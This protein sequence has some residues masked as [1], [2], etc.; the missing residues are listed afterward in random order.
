MSR[1]V[2]DKY[3]RNRVEVTISR[4]LSD[5]ICL[6]MK[7]NLTS[8]ASI[9]EVVFNDDMSVATV[10]VV[11]LDK[12]KT[13]LLVSFLNKKKGEIKTMLA[14]TLDIYKCPSLVFKKDDLYEKASKIDDLLDKVNN[15]KMQTLKDLK[16]KKKS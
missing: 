9:N 8:L 5:I 12:S 15:E 1:F 4:N 7:N 13:D 14:K 6:K 16:K 11:H 2:P 10:Y 3:K